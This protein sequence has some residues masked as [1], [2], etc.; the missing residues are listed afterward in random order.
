MSWHRPQGLTDHWSNKADTIY[1]SACEWE[2]DSL[3]LYYITKELWVYD[4]GGAGMLCTLVSK[5]HGEGGEIPFRRVIW[6][7]KSTGVALHDGAWTIHRPLKYSELVLYARKILSIRF[8]PV[9]YFKQFKRKINATF[10]NLNKKILN[11]LL[12]IYMLI[13]IY[14]YDNN[15]FTKDIRLSPCRLTNWYYFLQIRLQIVRA[16]GVPWRTRN[17][18]ITIDIAYVRHTVHIILN[19]CVI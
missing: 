2:W 17:E 14:S 3:C 11:I 5:L 8:K 15:S 10:Y 19:T 9:F 4:M 6:L 1:R 12:L 16:T 18:D 7:L 13:K